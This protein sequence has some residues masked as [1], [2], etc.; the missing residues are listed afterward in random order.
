[1]KKEDFFRACS[2][3]AGHPQNM[4]L[5]DPDTGMLYEAE[6]LVKK[7]VSLHRLPFADLTIV[8]PSFIHPA[9]ALCSNVLLQSEPLER[10]SRSY[11]TGFPPMSGEQE[12]SVGLPY[13]LTPE[14]MD[15]RLFDLCILELSRELPLRGVYAV[16]PSHTRLVFLPDASMVSHP[17]LSDA[18]PNSVPD[19]RLLSEGVFAWELPDPL[20]FAFFFVTS[21]TML[22]VRNN[23]LSSSEYQTQLAPALNPVSASLSDL[24]ALFASYNVYLYI[25]DTETQR[26]YVP[27]LP[28]IY[29]T[30]SL[31]LSQNC[32]PLLDQAATELTGKSLQ[33]WFSVAPCFTALSSMLRYWSLEFSRWNVTDLGTRARHAIANGLFD[34]DLVSMRVKP[35]DAKQI[36]D[37][38]EPVNVTLL[39]FA[40]SIRLP[41]RALHYLRL[42]E[43]AKLENANAGPENASGPNSGPGAD[44]G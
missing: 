29:P 18:L 23:E 12:S 35:S 36:L 6:L 42:F 30:G 21:P 27:P 22:I 15:R 3:I 40:A 38:C 31:C 5:V 37:F 16:T 25:Y 34:V 10:I 9:A 19:S 2:A 39:E 20:V 4:V 1:M 24:R 41:Q 14:F 7:P 28:N 11:G 32:P 44:S 17:C 8:L 33:R 13:S 26:F 43:A